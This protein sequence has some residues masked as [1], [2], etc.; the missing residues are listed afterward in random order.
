MRKS[1]QDRHV[2]ISTEGY[3]DKKIYSCKNVLGNLLNKGRACCR[4][5]CSE[6][7]SSAHEDTGSAS[8]AGERSAPGTGAQA[9]RL[10]THKVFDRQH[11]IC[12]WTNFN[13]FTTKEL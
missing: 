8:P 3:N 9:T 12:W 10:I 1:Y 11:L 7:V 4:R 2:S 6:A 5:G 13:I